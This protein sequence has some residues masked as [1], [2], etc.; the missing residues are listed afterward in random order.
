MQAR[1]DVTGLKNASFETVTED[2]S[3]TVESAKRFI[4]L[5]NQQAGLLTKEGEPTRTAQDKLRS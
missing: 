1:T 4:Q 3:P 2:V 5:Q